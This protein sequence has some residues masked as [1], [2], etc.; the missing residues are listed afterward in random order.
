MSHHLLY[1]TVVDEDV[2]LYEEVLLLVFV[3]FGV[4]RAV[5]RFLATVVHCNTEI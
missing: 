1:E 2:A 4:A 3:Q 5:V